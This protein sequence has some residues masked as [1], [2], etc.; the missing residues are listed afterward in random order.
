[1]GLNPPPEVCG[2]AVPGRSVP[3][4]LA[5]VGA[6]CGVSVQ[7]G[8]AGRTDRRAGRQPR[9]RT[10]NPRAAPASQDKCHHRSRGRRRGRQPTRAAGRPSQGQLSLVLCAKP[11]SGQE[12]L[13]LRPEV[14]QTPP[15]KQRASRTGYGT[16]SVAGTIPYQR[17]AF[18][19]SSAEA[20]RCPA[21]RTAASDNAARPAPGI[22]ASMRSQRGPDPVRVQG[23]AR[24][25]PHRDH[26]RPAAR[27][28]PVPG[29]TADRTRT[30]R[31]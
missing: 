26:Q 13:C 9:R 3:R 11:A 22:E 24:G 30:G 21:N 15:A 17:T 4:G 18:R 25:R 7:G 16:A 8:A 6:G 2:V 1:M 28:L 29:N 20:P 19:L 5:A 10:S 14:S 31:V 23:L 27:N 12:P